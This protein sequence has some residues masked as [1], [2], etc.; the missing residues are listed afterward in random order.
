M[1]ILAKATATLED[2]V[3]TLHPEVDLVGI[4]R[5]F[6]ED[7]VQRRL[8]PQRIL[9]TLASDAAGIGSILRTL[10]GQVDQLLHDYQSG[11][12]MVRAVTPQLDEV[13]QRL[14]ALGGRLSLAAFATATTIATAIAVPETTAS[15]PRLVAAAGLAL[16]AAISWTVL[17]AWHWFGT[18]MPVRVT[19]LLRLF[20]R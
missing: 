1:T 19:P 8:S 2:I 5:P 17:F 10:P 3:R 14:H 9:G 13:P 7:I 12:I 16:A 20:R 6:L 11:G 4:A 18:G 15:T